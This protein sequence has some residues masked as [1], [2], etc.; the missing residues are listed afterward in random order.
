MTF[1]SFNFAFPSSFWLL[2]NP[3]LTR[4][5]DKDPIKC[6]SGTLILYTVVHIGSNY[7]EVATT[8]AHPKSLSYNSFPQLHAKRF[9]TMGSSGDRYR[10]ANTK[11]FTNYSAN[12]KGQHFS[13]IFVPRYF[14]EILFLLKFFFWSL[15]KLFF[16]YFLMI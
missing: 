9:I 6:G 2:L 3:D 8:A 12:K 5:A 4:N 14:F 1:L 11:Y 7:L 15:S 16:I 13:S 10:M